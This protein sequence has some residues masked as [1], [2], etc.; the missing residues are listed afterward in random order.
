MKKN[1][2]AI[3]AKIIGALLPLVIMGCSPDYV[4]EYGINHGKGIKVG[5]VVWA[6]VNCGYHATDYPW[7]KLYQWGRKYGQGYS[8]NLYDGD[9]NVL[10]QVLDATTPTLVEGP[11][12]LEVGNS[13]SCN[14]NV[15]YTDEDYNHK[16]DWLSHHNTTLW[17]SGTEKFPV[18]TEFDPCPK[19]WRVPTFNELKA[20][21]G[22]TV[23]KLGQPGYWFSGSYSETSP[24]VFF[25]AAGSRSFDFGYAYD[26]GNCGYYWSSYPGEDCAGCAD[27]LCFRDDKVYWYQGGRADGLSVRCVQD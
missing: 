22:W 9:G 20:L 19:G 25:P 2:K 6:P 24:R 11:V 17:N 16:H 10:C 27:G 8:G 4:D 3:V 13:D 14:A 23:N 5:G 1:Y 21:K 18:K 7:G 15:F 26:R 12:S